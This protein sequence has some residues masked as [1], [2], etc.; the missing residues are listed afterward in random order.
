MAQVVSLSPGAE[1]WLDGKTVT[2]LSQAT[3]ET[4][5]VKD[6]TGSTKLVPIPSLSATPTEAEPERKD[7]DLAEISQEDWDLARRR[8]AVIQRLVSLSHRTR[9]LVEVGAEELGC[10]ATVVYRLIAR[11]EADPCTTSL[12]PRKRG[13]PRGLEM[14]PVDIERIVAATI[15][16]FYLNRQRVKGS[17]VVDEVRKRCRRADLPPPGKMTVYRRL[18]ALPQKAV[19]KARHGAKT[20]RDQFGVV[21]GHFPET[22][23][24]LEVVQIDHTPVDVIAV[25]EVHRRPIGRPW[26]TL[27]IDIHTRMVVGFLL[28]LDP[29][30]A[31]SVALCLV[32]GMLAKDDWLTRI[33]VEVKWPV[34]GMPSTLHVD[35]AKEFRSE[36]LKR[37]AEQHGVTIDY[38]PVRTP[39][40]GGHIERLIGT[41]MGKVHLLPSA[42]FSNVAEKGDYDAEKHATMTLPEIEVWLTLGIDVYHRK[43]H[44]A[45]G[46]P[47]ISAWERGLLGTPEA[48]GRGLPPRIANPERL[49]IDFLPIERRQVTREGVRLFN[50]HYWSDALRPLI[51]NPQRFLLRYDPRDISRIWLLSTDGEYYPLGY[52][53]RHRPVISLWEQREVTRRLR[54]EGR[55]KVDEA[56]IFEGIERMRAVVAK[57]AADTKRARRQAERTRQAHRST[58]TTKPTTPTTAPPAATDTPLPPPKPFDVEE[59]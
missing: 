27:A 6:E 4:V 24:P 23:F 44:S 9:A 31:T 18:N 5:L 1:V 20:A 50:V 43:L 39:H 17:E 28:S 25:D 52:R 33:G 19:V 42:T 54:E 14:L 15:E 16:E 26:L 32:H 7:V 46:E 2:I 34:W 11:Y 55:K 47:P 56:A 12:L 48:P 3:L 35:N 38:R 30:S 10:T 41:M 8:E 49:L 21:T 45:L 51:D 59:W 22:Q 13:K 37:G 40:Y 58:G 29:P 53:A 36:A 57:A